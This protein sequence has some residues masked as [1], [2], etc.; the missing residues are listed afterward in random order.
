MVTFIQANLRAACLAPVGLVKKGGTR[1]RVPFV[2]CGNEFAIGWKGFVGG[3]RSMLS[4]AGQKQ[5]GVMSAW[6]AEPWGD[7]EAPER[8]NP[9]ARRRSAPRPAN[10]GDYV[11]ERRR[12]QARVSKVG[13]R[14]LILAAANRI[15][16][17]TCRPSVPL[18]TPG[19][20]RRRRRGRTSASPARPGSTRSGGGPARPDLPASARARPRRVAPRHGSR[21][22]ARLGLQPSVQ[23]A[24]GR[25]A[26]SF[27]LS[28]PLSPDSG[29]VPPTPLLRPDHR[30][31]P[32]S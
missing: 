17:A 14:L 5:C 8:G 27:V 21:R 28:R 29:A 15:A 13:L 20:R 16:S 11:A 22:P 25:G 26:R 7:A 30:S 18:P 3:Y 10:G 31:S 9:A 4:E 6:S 2:T 19:P 23:R 24:T 32:A 1:R 12:R